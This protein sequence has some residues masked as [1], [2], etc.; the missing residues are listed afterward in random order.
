METTNPWDPSEQSVA[1]KTA[2][3]PS[4][5]IFRFH[6]VPPKGLKYTVKADRRKI[7]R[8]VYAGSR[9]IDLDAIEGEAAELIERDP[10]QAERFFGNRVVYGAGS[11]ADGEKWDARTLPREVPDG[12]PVVLG[13][14]GSDVDDWTGIRAELQDGY[15]FTPTFGVDKRPTIWNPAEHAGQ[16]PRLEV[17]AAIDELFARFKVIRM[18]ADPPDW[19]SELDELAAKHG[20]KRVIRWETYRAVQMHAAAERLLTDIGKADSPFTHDGC[21]ITAVHVKNARKVARPG[22]RYVLAKPNQGQKID[23]CV[24]SILCHEAAGD[25]TAAKLWLG[26]QRLTRVT[27]KV[28]G[29]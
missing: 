23:L 15:Q 21:P 2:E 6:R 14:D 7:H 19:K 27:G 4:K 8:F 3:S 12:V 16:V 26:P 18:Y 1:Q 5:D 24:T 11:W 9:H 13:F 10:Q 25:V 29:Y 22:M 28:S 20:D 17:L